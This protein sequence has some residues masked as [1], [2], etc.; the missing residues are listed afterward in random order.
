MKLRSHRTRSEAGISLID[1]LVYI[2]L[3][4]VLLT[5][6]TRFFSVVYHHNKAAAKA[7]G[8]TIAALDAAKQWRRDIANAKG[9]PKLI[10]DVHFDVI[11]IDQANGEQVSYR[12]N[13]T[14]LERHNG[15]EWVPIIRRIASSIMLPDQREQV[16]AWRWELAMETKSRFLGNPVRFSFTAVPGHPLATRP[17]KAQPPTP[18]PIP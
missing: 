4:A 1:G 15:E 16:R 6:A 7:A 14:R 13:G 5:C 3:F 2:A 12:V 11:R 9:E 10:R 17:T 8:Y 18:E